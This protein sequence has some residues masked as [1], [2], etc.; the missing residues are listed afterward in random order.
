MMTVRI[1]ASTA[2]A[3]MYIPHPPTLSSTAFRINPT[4]QTPTEHTNNPDEYKQIFVHDVCIFLVT[5]LGPP[6]KIADRK[7]ELRGKL[8]SI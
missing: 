2:P 1:A 4:V 6:T 7:I 8:T 5:H 3:S